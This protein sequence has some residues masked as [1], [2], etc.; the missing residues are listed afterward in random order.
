MNQQNSTS[1]DRRGFTLIEL[2]LAMAFVS[3]LLMTIAFTVI[4]VGTIY[5]SGMTIKEVNQSSREVANELQQA[6]G[7]ATALTISTGADSQYVTIGTG[8]NIYGGRICLGSYSYVWNTGWGLEQALSQVNVAAYLDEAGAKKTAVRFAKVPDVAKKYCEKN[9]S[10]GLVNVNI[11][12]AD[13]N[14]SKELLAAG[15]RNIAIQNITLT[16][17]PA[18]DSIKQGLYR[19]SYTLG[20]G[21]T[22]TMNPARTACL[23]PDDDNAD[24]SYCNIQQFT[25]TLRTGNAAKG[26]GA[27]VY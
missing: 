22:I 8:A 17:G 3:V 15:D 1:T 26:T 10:N 13:A 21:K 6:A 25:I 12:S 9:A 2:M 4:R 27:T 14:V 24:P 16:K 23:P 20:A 7:A 18:D 11:S 5:N 19:L